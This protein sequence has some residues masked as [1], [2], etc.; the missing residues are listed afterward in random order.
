[1]VRP[2]VNPLTSSARRP[3]RLVRYLDPCRRRGRNI[4][5]ALIAR[6]SSLSASGAWGRGA[7]PGTDPGPWAR[8]GRERR[9]RQTDFRKRPPGLGWDEA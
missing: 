4:A 6:R 5:K 3:P 2:Y 7:T 8:T 9:A 1:M